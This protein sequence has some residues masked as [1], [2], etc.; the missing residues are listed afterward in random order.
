MKLTAGKR[1]KSNSA[2]PFIKRFIAGFLTAVLVVP[3]LVITF[4]GKASAVR[5]QTLL[6]LATAKTV[7]ICNSEKIEAIEMQI[8]AKQAARESAIRSLKEKERSMKT[9]RWSPLLNFWFP[10][11]PN[12]AEAFEFSYKPT[13]LQYD[14]DTLKHKINDLKLQENEKVSGIYIDI[15]TS[16]A[17][18]T[19]LNQRI[20]NLE[21]TLLKNKA[22]LALGLATEAQIKMQ[23]KKLEGYKKSLSSEKTK[24]QRSKDKLGKEVGFTITDQYIFE[25]AFITTNIDRKMVE[26]LQQHA[27][28]TTRPYLRPSRPRLSPSWNL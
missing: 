27:R 13:Q 26:K 14:I 6:S 28:K 1:G 8:E 2:R 3:S 7:A 9:F 15:I 19:F 11:T 18:I 12:E 22:R 5:R 4:P 24:L 21:S 25:D 23:E 20:S 16:T 10:T 17:E